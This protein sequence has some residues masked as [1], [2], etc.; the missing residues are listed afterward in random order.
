MIKRISSIWRKLRLPY[1][2]GL[3]YTPLILLPAL[4]GIYYVTDSY[5]S[6]SKMRTAEYA[7]DLLSLMGQKIN[8]RMSSYQQLSKQIMT[9][10]DLIRAIQADPVSSYDRFQL[11]GIINEKLNVLW[12]GADQ[13]EYI[14][15]IMVETPKSLFTYGKSAYGDYGVNHSEYRSQVGD[16]KGAARW[17]EP[18]TY[19]DGY[20][21][22]QA[23]RLGRTI[24]D[25]KLNELGT[26]TI[27]IQVEAF[28]DIFNQTRFQEDAALK[29]LAKDGGVLIDNGVVIAPEEK[30]LLTFS[31][32]KLQNGWTLSAQLPLKQLY[33]PIYNN[34]RLAVYFVLVCI[35]LGLIVTH[36]LALDLVIPIRR[37]MVNMKL[38][39]RGVR[40]GQLK[41]LKG[42][43]EVVEMNDTFISVMYEIE[44]LIDQV[45]KQEK[46]K[47]DAEIRVLQNQLSPHFLYNTLNS[48][49][50]MAMI[51][52]QDNIKEMVDSLNQLLTYALRRSGDPVTLADEIA[53][54]S[55]YVAI[56][57]V[58]YQ[59]FGFTTSIPASLEKALV[60][61]FLLQ[62]LIENALIHGLSPSEHPGEI[63]V[64]AW[65]ED[66]KLMVMVSDNGIG[67]TPERLKEMTNGLMN[68]DQ[69]FGLHSVHERIQLH[70]GPQ[71]G[72]IIQSDANE[73][74]RITVKV[75]LIR[76]D[77]N[78]GEQHA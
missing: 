74:T 27:V 39:I 34:V 31:E 65:E 72:L 61:K 13:N 9:D 53:M 75:P 51:Q 49:R 78:G 47:K 66:E 2:L 33:E 6:A 68:P 5:T 56:Q 43:V 26:L 15:S 36:L 37:L 45:A 3:V 41:H 23:F 50:W 63:I 7:T 38:G 24:R 64:E 44:H 70:Y 73:G 46:K 1:K 52:K 17:F 40:P 10:G 8:D 48:I 58:R 14:R 62:P 55:N 42:A 29:L 76:A 57:K 22:F 71:Y 16:M 19:G 28:T 25:S 32:D 11:E 30:Q 54:L 59:H 21:E 18:E 20:I 35:L 69:H 77:D 12:L 67:M 60:L 4:A